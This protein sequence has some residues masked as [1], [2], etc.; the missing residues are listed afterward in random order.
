[1]EGKVENSNR[2]K[3]G[4]ERLA[5]EDVEM[6]RILKKYFEELYYIGTEEQI[7]FYIWGFEEVWRGNYFGR[8]VTRRTEGEVREGKLKSRKATGNGEVTG[9]MIKGGSNWI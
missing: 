1:M 6:Q 8:E 9:E 7:A 2:I 4:N 3:D 5:L